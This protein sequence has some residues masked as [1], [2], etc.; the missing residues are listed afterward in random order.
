M[1]PRR[2]VS[3]LFAS[4]GVVLATWAVHLPTVQ[5]TTGVSKSI[6]GTYLLLV[7][8]GALGGMQISARLIDRLGSARVSLTASALMAV[9][10]L[11]PLA[12]S[13][14]TQAALGALL[15]GVA[16]GNAD[17]AINAAAVEVERFYG[18]PIMASFHG[19]FSVGT[20]AGS[21]I[22]AAGYAIG[23]PILIPA[24]AASVGCVAIIGCVSAPTL[25]RWQRSASRAT[26]DVQAPPDGAKRS[27]WRVL[28]LGL[29]AALLLLPEG[30]AMDW[31]SLHAQQHLG[32]PPTIG[33]LAFA[34]FCAATTIG[35]FTVDKLVQRLGPVRIV[36]YGSIAS[37]TGLLIV[38]ASPAIPLTLIGWAILGLGLAGGVP[39][40]FTAAGNADAASASALSR[41]VALGYLA[42]LAGPAVIGWLADLTSLNAA[43]VLPLCSVVIAGCLANTVRPHQSDAAV[44]RDADE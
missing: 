8:L 30:S 10:V 14:P 34:T 20:V 12:A 24:I 6:L 39:Q 27:R 32:A 3:I 7:G 19:L 18:R 22:G 21:V 44:A 41:V 25:L 26:P 36:R 17:V 35:R 42:I 13:T 31:S 5:H 37:A 43:L 28:L 2:A 4:F 23:G 11:I 40:V 1:G 9:L 29:M 15:F 38:I 16:A 33:T